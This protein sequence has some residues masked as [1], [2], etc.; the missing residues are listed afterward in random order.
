MR[1]RGPGKVGRFDKTD[2]SG[3][4]PMKQANQPPSCKCVQLPSQALL[5]E[6][7]SAHLTRQEKGLSVKGDGEAV[8]SERLLV[9]ETTSK[10]CGVRGLRKRA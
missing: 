8:P 9:F 2:A 10:D 7:T 6:S 3:P 5:A 4:E 1:H